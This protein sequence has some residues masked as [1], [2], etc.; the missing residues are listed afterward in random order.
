MATG[1]N[2]ARRLIAGVLGGGA[3]ALFAGTAFAGDIASFRPIGFSSDG[4]VF[5]FEEF[6]VQD[7]SGFPYSNIFVIDTIADRYLPGSP[8]RVRL[9]SDGASLAAA[10]EKASQQAA[11]LLAKHEP[12]A[13]PGLLAAFNP[14]TA[15]DAPPHHLRYLPYAMVPSF[16]SPYTLELQEIPQPPAPRCEGLVESSATF[17]LKLVERDGN[18]A[19]EIVHEDARLPESRNCATGYRLGGVMTYHPQDGAPVHVA[20]V[21]VLSHGFEGSDGRWIAIP[22]RP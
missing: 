5:A 1:G 4:S 17:R 22:F 10:R 14:V 9:D 18:P 8:V 2:C 16:G 12:T 20:L 15:V 3:L 21:L 6:G 11:P 7:G 13:H 19:D